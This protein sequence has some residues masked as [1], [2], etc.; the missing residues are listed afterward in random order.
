MRTRWHVSASLAVTGSA[1]FLT[2]SPWSQDLADVARAY[3]QRHGV[4]C[5]AVTHVDRTRQD[6]ELVAICQDGRQ[7]A[8]FMVEGE[9]AFLDPRT[10]APYRWHYDVYRAHPELYAASPASQEQATA[11]RD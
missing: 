2:L 5:H 6:M 8:L 10:R 1:L 4:P 11:D 9:V 3:L 7:W